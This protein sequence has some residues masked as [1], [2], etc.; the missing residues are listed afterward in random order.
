MFEGYE[1]VDILWTLGLYAVNLLALL[2]VLT[3][4]KGDNT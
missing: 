4:T 3:H 2:Y 1:L